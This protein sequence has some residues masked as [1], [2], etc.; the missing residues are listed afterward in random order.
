M[1]GNQLLAKKSQLNALQERVK[2][3]DS[4]P[5]ISSL[6][7]HVAQ[8]LSELRCDIRLSGETKQAIDS[9]RR[10]SEIARPLATANPTVTWF[11]RVLWQ[12]RYNEGYFFGGS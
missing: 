3:A 4:H 2:L 11:Q 9:C 5:G 8:T 12:S 1:S 10:A 7:V 6:Q